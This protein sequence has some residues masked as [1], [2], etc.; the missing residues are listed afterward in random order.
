MTKSSDE[1]NKDRARSAAVPGPVSHRKS[2][3]RRAFWIK[4]RPCPPI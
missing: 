3:A 4:D 1:N 2:A